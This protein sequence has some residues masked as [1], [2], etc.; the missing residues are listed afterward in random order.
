MNG[1]KGESYTLLSDHIKSQDKEITLARKKL[2]ETHKKW[3]QVEPAMNAIVA[4]HKRV[5]GKEQQRTYEQYLRL[6]E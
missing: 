6:Y 3:S 1:L 5:F 2:S 4:C